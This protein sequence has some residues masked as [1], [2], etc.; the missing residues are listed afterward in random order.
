[1]EKFDTE[2]YLVDWR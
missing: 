1:M 2:E